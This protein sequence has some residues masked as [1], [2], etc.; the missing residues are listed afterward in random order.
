MEIMGALENRIRKSRLHA[1]ISQAE[2]AEKLN[3][4]LR[5]A[6]RYEKD[7]TKISLV[8]TQK[9][10]HICN[11]NEVWLL[12]G[13]GEML[14]SESEKTETRSNEAISFD[15][16]NGAVIEHRD[17][18]KKFRNKERAKNLDQKLVELES[19]SEKS[20]KKA[21]NYIY[22][23]VDIVRCVIDENTEKIEDRQAG[24]GE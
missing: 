1:N 4:S 22:E 3:V 13:K 11:V 16:N 14:L 19:L 5:S 10:A 15:D 9:L 23:L 18:I 12:T 21:E 2:M 6:N 24:N 17:I 7:A 8:V 20:F